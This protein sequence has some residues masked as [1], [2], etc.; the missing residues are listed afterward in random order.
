M[1]DSCDIKV[2]LLYAHYMACIILFF[3]IFV[4]IL[5]NVEKKIIRIIWPR[6]N[7]RA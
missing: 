6:Q 7:R 3:Y 2:G 1:A 4:Y 5:L